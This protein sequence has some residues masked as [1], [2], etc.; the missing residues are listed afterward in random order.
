M[1]TTNHASC[2]LVFPEPYKGMVKDPRNHESQVTVIEAATYFDLPPLLVRIGDWAISNEGIHCL[3]SRYDITK[4]RFDE[5][6]WV[7]HVTEKTWVDARD[8]RAIFQF[9]K[10]MKELGYL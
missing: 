1:S 3:T 7:E 2:S 6:D 8:F 5:S 10:D 4:S 9:A